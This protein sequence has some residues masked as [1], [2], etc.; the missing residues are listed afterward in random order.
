MAWRG[1]EQHEMQRHSAMVTIPPE[2]VN[3]TRSIAFAVFNVVSCFYGRLDLE[4]LINRS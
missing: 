3:E 1:T 2:T 4:L